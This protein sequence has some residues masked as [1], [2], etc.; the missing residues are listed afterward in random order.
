MIRS[1][2]PLAPASTVRMSSDSAPNSRRDAC[3]PPSTEGTQ[4]ARCL[5]PV[6][7][8]RGISVAEFR[9]EYLRGNKPVVLEGFMDDWPA[10][11]TWSVDWFRARYSDVRVTA[12]RMFEKQWSC[13]LGEY[14]DYARDFPR[15]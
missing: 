10:L 6:E 8:R 2:S 5:G 3:A 14:L 15:A 13:S 7:R 9:R 11:R 12:T 1:S 4:A